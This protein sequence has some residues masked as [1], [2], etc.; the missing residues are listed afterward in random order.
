M[1]YWVQFLT[2]ST[3]YI[4]GSIPPKFGKPELIDACGDMAVFI[5]DG[6]NS[7]ETM[8]ADAMKRAQQLE[9]WLQYPAFQIVTGPR[10]FD[11]KRRGPVHTL[12]YPIHV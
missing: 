11:E 8:R 2:L 3:G 12:T 1:K 10:L 9:H 6:R 4:A 7:Q 5:L